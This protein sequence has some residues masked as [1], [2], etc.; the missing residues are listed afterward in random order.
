MGFQESPGD[1]GPRKEGL[2][3]LPFAVAGMSFIPLVGILFGLVSIVWGIVAWARGGWKLLVM[4]VAG[5]G[6]TLG[7]YGALFYFGIMVR[8]GVYDKLRAQLA[9]QMLVELAKNVEFFKT[10][11]G[12][13]PHALEELSRGEQRVIIIDPTDVSGLT[14]RRPPRPFNYTLDPEK[15][16]YDL[17]AV[18][19]D[20]V[21]FT[22][23]DL[24]PVFSPEELAKMG[25]RVR[26]AGPPSSPSPSPAASPAR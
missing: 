17:R 18:G 23:D 22:E 3:C 11:N 10:I 16:T 5:I 19:V 4:G 26:R 21:P 25:L 12:R 9:S 20:G 24:V 13:Y 8:G 14:N 2:G 6:M 7:L 1:E 15:K